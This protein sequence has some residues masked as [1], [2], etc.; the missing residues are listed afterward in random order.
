M[1]DRVLPSTPPLILLSARMPLVSPVC[2][3]VLAWFAYRLR[4]LCGVCVQDL[5]LSNQS[6]TLWASDVVVAVDGSV[7]EL[8]ALS[9]NP[10]ARRTAVVTVR[11]AVFLSLSLS[12]T[13]W[14]SHYACRAAF[15]PPLF[16]S[17]LD[18]GRRLCRQKATH[19]CTFMAWWVVCK[20]RG[21]LL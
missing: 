3:R 17:L 13:R 18:V 12:L 8:A 16:P 9:M 7:L 4:C 21:V 19:T 6:R 11:A 15:P 5:P 10:A 1:T 2:C 20:R 14:L